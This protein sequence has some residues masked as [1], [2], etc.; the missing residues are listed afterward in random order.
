V[1]PKDEKSW[2]TASIDI[3]GMGTHMLHEFI[4]GGWDEGSVIVLAMAH[5]VSLDGKS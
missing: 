2:R 5:T 4:G 1:L 3:Y